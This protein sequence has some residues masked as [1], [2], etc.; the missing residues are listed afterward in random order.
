MALGNLVG[1]PF[2]VSFFIL[3]YFSR[4]FFTSHKRITWQFW[5]RRFRPLCLDPFLFVRTSHLSFLLLSFLGVDSRRL[6]SGGVRS[7]DN[8]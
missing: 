2:P 8:K 7:S 5:G 6:C 4:L 1:G 3:S